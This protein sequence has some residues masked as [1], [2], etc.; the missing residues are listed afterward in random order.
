M[1]LIAAPVMAWS[2]CH[3]IPCS[4]RRRRD[5]QPAGAPCCPCAASGV[6][7]F[8]RR[9][10]VQPRPA[11]LLPMG[12]TA[13]VAT[14]SGK[15]AESDSDLHIKTDTAPGTA[16]VPV[17]QPL[18]VGAV[19]VLEAAPPIFRW[20]ERIA[21]TVF[22]QWCAPC[23][24]RLHRPAAHRLRLRGGAAQRLLSPPAGKPTRPPAPIPSRLRRWPSSAPLDTCPRRAG[25]GGALRAPG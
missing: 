17:R 20:Q 15:A 11:A 16:P 1:L 4:H 23:G 2:R 14:H 21:A 6:K 24:R 7:P 12:A 25:G 9:L 8:P 19:M 5:G 10:P 22:E 13:D 18:F 3:R